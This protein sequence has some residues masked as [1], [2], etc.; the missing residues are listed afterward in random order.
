MKDGHNHRRALRT[1]G[2]EWT[3]SPVAPLRLVV[4]DKSWTLP[5]RGRNGR[6]Q[7][8]ADASPTADVTVLRNEVDEDPMGIFWG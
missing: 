7:R 5:W 4:R 8:Y 1:L 3:S 2:P 6:W